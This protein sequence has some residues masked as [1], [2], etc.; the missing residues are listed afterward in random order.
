LKSNCLGDENE[1]EEVSE[2]PAIWETGY[3]LAVIAIDQKGAKLETFTWL[4]N[5][6]T[7]FGFWAIGGTEHHVPLTWGDNCPT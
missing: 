4:P 5:I 7:E 6:E 3:Y 2:R 1:E